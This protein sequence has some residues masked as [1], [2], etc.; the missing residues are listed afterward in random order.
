[1]GICCS[2]C[3]QGQDNIILKAGKNS[4]ARRKQLEKVSQ[5]IQSIKLTEIQL[6]LQ[7]EDD[8]FFADKTLLSSEKKRKSDHRYD[9]YKQKSREHFMNGSVDSFKGDED[10]SEV[11]DPFSP[12]M[13]KKLAQLNPD[14]SQ[15]MYER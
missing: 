6:S 13:K 9:L 5:T 7:E 4:E 12:G 15:T 2:I 1:M 14:L 3:G 10:N 8:W 11:E